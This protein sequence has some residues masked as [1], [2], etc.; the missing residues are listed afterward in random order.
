MTSPQPLNDPL[1]KITPI[2]NH[3]QVIFKKFKAKEYICIDEQVVPFK[4]RSLIKQDN[5]NK[6]K[7][8]SYN[9]MF[10]VIAKD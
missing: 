5:P 3:L 1:Y 8:W 2:I 4:G 10:H 6:P 9:C 7:K